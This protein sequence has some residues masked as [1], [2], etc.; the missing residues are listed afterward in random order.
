M[1][2]TVVGAW[3]KINE[4]PTRPESEFGHGLIL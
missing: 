2:S 1:A 3:N 4:N